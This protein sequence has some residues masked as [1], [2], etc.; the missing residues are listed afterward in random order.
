MLRPMPHQEAARG[1]LISSLY[2]ALF[3]YDYLTPTEQA[4]IPRSQFDD[5]VEWLLG[6]RPICQDCD[7]II[8]VKEQIRYILAC[9][10]PSNPA[11][12]P[13]ICESCASGWPNH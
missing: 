12:V 6:D 10:F 2:D 7:V 8:G 1:L 4:M 9:N 13:R 3:N 11:R 5:L